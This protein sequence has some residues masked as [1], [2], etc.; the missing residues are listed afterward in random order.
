MP[1]ILHIYLEEVKKLFLDSQVIW[2]IHQGHHY[3][4]RVYNLFKNHDMFAEKNLSNL[5]L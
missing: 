4:D 3:H 2:L 5:F 1:P